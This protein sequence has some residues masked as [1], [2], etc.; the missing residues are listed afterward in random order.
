MA[1][2]GL[3]SADA[4][5][6]DRSGVAE[7]PTPDSPD[8][9]RAFLWGKRQSRRHPLALDVY[10]R[11]ALGEIAA[12]SMDLSA[13][14]VLLRIAASALAPD[15]AVEGEVDPF[16]LVQTHFRQACPA[17][18]RKAGVT[19]HIEVVRLDVRPEDPDFVY[20]GCRFSHPL[21]AEQL[22]RFSLD[23]EECASELHVLPS[24]M[25][26]LQAAGD[27]C[28]CRLYDVGGM[29]EPIFEGTVLGIGEG[30][31]CMRVE[32]HHATLAAVGLC[33]RELRIEVLTGDKVDWETPAWLQTIGFPGND[34]SELELGLVT[35][36]VPNKKLR[37]RFRRQ[38]TAA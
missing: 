13:D 27:P 14:G 3:Y 1:P 9:L 26:P 17:E 6:A 31:L 23:L 34:T 8:A 35:E 22:R 10:V 30:T 7:Q 5:F 20:V 15:A 25:M 4:R 12:M 37:R 2:S 38:S 21:K 19:A 24:E 16:L 28:V 29:S 33:A 18:F 11:G 32:G 36:T